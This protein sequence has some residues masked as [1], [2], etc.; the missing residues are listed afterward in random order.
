MSDYDTWKSAYLMRL[1]RFTENIMLENVEFF[2]SLYALLVLW[3]VKRSNSIKIDHQWNNC[4]FSLKINCKS[5]LS[6]LEEVLCKR[7]WLV[8]YFEDLR[9]ISH[10]TAISRHGSG[11]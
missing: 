4:G 1:N 2:A 8:G 7:S 5:H 10:L 9:R 11:R 3:D 6:H